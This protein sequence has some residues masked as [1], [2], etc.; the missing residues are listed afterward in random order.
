M[1]LAQDDHCLPT[2]VRWLA[3]AAVAA[4]CASIVAIMAVG[5]LGPSAAVVRFPSA[6][7]WPPYFW[8]AG[9]SDVVISL[10]IWAAVL[11]GGSGVVAGLLATR[12]GWRPRPRRLLIGSAVA[13]IAMLLM[14]P[15]GST[16]V[17]DYAAYGRIAALGHSPYVMTPAQLRSSGDPVGLAAPHTWQ[18]NPY[19]PIA[20]VTER[21]ASQLAGDSAARTV[22]WIK[23]WN[24]LAYLSVALALDR[25]LRSDAA[26]RVRAHLLW[27]VNPLML[28]AVIEAGH[29]DGLGVG[30]GLAGLLAMRRVDAVHGLLAGALVG[31]AVAVKAP[32]ALFGGG[33][34]WAARRSPLTLAALALG[35]AAVLVPSYLLAGP[36]AVSA[37]TNAA[38]GAVDLY[39]PWQLLSRMLHWHPVSP[40]TDAVALVA[41]LLLGVVLLWRFR[42]ARPARDQAGPGPDTR[43]ADPRTAAAPLVR[44]HDLPAPC[45]DAGHPAGLDRDRPGRRGDSSR[46]AGRAVL[47]WAASLLALPDRGSPLPRARAADSLGDRGRRALAVRQR[48]L[49]IPGRPGWP[50]RRAPSRPAS[51]EFSGR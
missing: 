7:P 48:S 44:R 27:S 26:L 31:V 37:V 45:R 10:I 51:A 8:H 40:R 3:R 19:G 36:G 50:G 1:D 16:D 18:H 9:P 34:C 29:V 33:L 6:A 22:F 12:R 35:A 38:H 14:P 17:L 28:F 46:I 32:F 23:I 13:V 24:A 5:L 42:A 11:L 15:I 20:T 39:Q 41:S 49:D 47:P 43:L 2:S 25:L 4:L 30:A 21:A